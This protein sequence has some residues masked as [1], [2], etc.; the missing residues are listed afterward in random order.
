[1]V[2]APKSARAPGPQPIEDSLDRNVARRS[3]RFY[4]GTAQLTLIL[5]I[6]LSTMHIAWLVSV[7]AVVFAAFLGLGVFSRFR[8]SK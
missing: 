4:F 8:H 3:A 6:V 7:L 2:P 5:L 1:V